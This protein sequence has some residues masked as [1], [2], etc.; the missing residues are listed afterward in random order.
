MIFKTLLIALISF[1]ASCFA[2]IPMPRDEV[3]HQVIG[4]KAGMSF[5]HSL[6]SFK[7]DNAYTRVESGEEFW[8]I[9]YTGDFNLKKEFHNA[10]T[11]QGAPR[12]VKKSG[13]FTIVKRGSNWYY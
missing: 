11:F 10:S 6:A 8:V 7:I 12:K 13:A 4:E 1:S 2:D 9:E 3:I 5:T